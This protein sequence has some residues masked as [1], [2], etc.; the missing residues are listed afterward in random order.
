[1]VFDLVRPSADFIRTHAGIESSNNSH[2]S[3]NP[4]VVGSKSFNNDSH[5]RLAK[6]E[7]LSH[8]NETVLTTSLPLDSKS[9]GHIGLKHS[10]ANKKSKTSSSH[11][12]DDT[13][14]KSKL[15]K[16][17]TDKSHDAAAVLVSHV[18]KR[19]VAIEKSATDTS[20][21]RSLPSM[22]CS[23]P[24]AITN[25]AE[26][27]SS[28]LSKHKDGR[29]SSFSAND[30]LSSATKGD[31]LPHTKPANTDNYYVL[32]AKGGSIPNVQQNVRHGLKTSVRKVVQQ[33]RSSRE[34]SPN[35]MPVESEVGIKLLR[36]N[37]VFTVSI[38]V[39]VNFTSYILDLYWQMGFPYEIFT[40]LY[41]YDKL[42]LYPF[43]LTNCGNRY[44]RVLLALH[45]WDIICCH[46]YCVVRERERGRK[47]GR[48][49]QG[50]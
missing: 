49:E 7:A 30:R 1:M 2:S 31:L 45:N 24:E 12:A 20:K 26:E 14:F 43:G 41:C 46:C 8:A 50:V 35:L 32:S 15:P 5:S 4:S 23:S 48:R 28:Y 18:P 9:S 36:Y 27:E 16:T 42:E 6:S 3:F 11:I 25:E 19:K 21:H 44:C 39:S 29:K 37:I 34:L 17:K 47:E 40:E 33:F 10:N 13:G 38:F 22:N